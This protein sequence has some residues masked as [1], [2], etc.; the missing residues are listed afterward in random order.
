MTFDGL[1]RTNGVQPLWFALLVVVFRLVPGDLAPLRVVAGIETC[2]LAGAAVMLFGALRARLGTVAAFVAA[3]ALAALPR[4]DEILRRGMESALLL[5]ML[6][7]AWQATRRASERQ[8]TRAWLVAGALWALAFLTRLEV[9]L[10]P[11]LVAG[12][13]AT[14]FR[15]RAR[16][17][18]ALLLPTAVVAVVYATLNRI[19]FG[20]VLP[21]SGLVK[22]HWGAAYS[23][24]E[25]LRGW[26]NFPWAL[27]DLVIRM[28]SC[29]ALV[30]S[31]RAPVKAG[32]LLVEALLL[33]ILVRH[34]RAAVA[35]LRE[36]TA[37]TLLALCAVLIVIDVS[38][39]VR[40]ATWKEAPI[41]LGSALLLGI[42]GH[43]LPRLA[44]GL[45]IGVCALALL[46]PLSLIVDA[47]A[48][49]GNSL[50]RVQA[51]R[52]LAGNLPPGDK[53]GSWNAGML[54]Y[55]SHRTVVNLDGLVNDVAF[56]RRV[57]DG[58]DLAGYLRD[59]HI[60]WLSDQGCGT[61]PRPRTLLASGGAADLDP[62]FAVVTT[63]EQPTG[64]SCRGYAIWRRP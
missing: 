22:S 56:Y 8:S 28:F 30:T 23:S 2:L 25:H 42:V 9:L 21:I 24:G 11:L 60:R 43:R 41:V 3:V 53:V 55:F 5:F 1:H 50:F 36:S 35:A 58:G 34:R 13:H 29:G 44:P 15:S 61:N 49:A 20:T 10:A 46:R 31:C 47:D 26:I 52:W 32:Y 18:G 33:L 40:M 27:H 54:G 7:A 16:F 59:E 48:P 63:F 17:A 12:L 51:A 4:A 45:A 19:F 39:V 62:Q 14:L 38:V 37:G 64:T 6:I 57:V